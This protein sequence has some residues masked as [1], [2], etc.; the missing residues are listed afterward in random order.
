MSTPR[1]VAELRRIIA[2]AG[3][4]NGETM[5]PVELEAQHD[6]KRIPGQE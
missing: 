6:A 3:F 4:L 1:T 5:K 2:G